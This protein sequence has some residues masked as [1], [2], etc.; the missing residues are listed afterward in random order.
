MFNAY[1]NRFASTAQEIAQLP[2][3]EPEGCHWLIQVPSDNPEPDFPED[4]YNIVECGAPVT[5]NEYGSWSCEAG[6]YHV[7]Y[8]DPMRPAFEIELSMLEREEY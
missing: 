3:P 5:T 2:E 1:P 6:H 8:D 4:L 7:S